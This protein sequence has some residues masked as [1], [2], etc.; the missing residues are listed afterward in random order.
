M[1][2]RFMVCIGINL[3]LFGCSVMASTSA[4]ND[5][6]APKRELV[7]SRLFSLSNQPIPP[8]TKPYTPHSFSGPSTDACGFEK[9]EMETDKRPEKRTIWLDRYETFGDLFASYLASMD[10]DG[11]QPGDI[12]I[13]VIRKPGTEAPR[14]EVSVRFW[15][16]PGEGEDRY[17][18]GGGFDFE[19]EGYEYRYVPGSLTCSGSI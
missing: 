18:T 14:W 5:V 7:L 8:L 2:M 17:A 1:S 6:P 15:V 12:N 16:I 19:L 10:Y 4:I 9:L 11:G 3:L 13:E